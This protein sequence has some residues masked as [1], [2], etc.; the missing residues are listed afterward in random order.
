M[1]P[2][3]GYC[4]NKCIICWRPVEY[5]EGIE[6]K[7]D[8]DDPKEVVENSIEL[9]KKQLMGFKGNE[10]VNM[11]KFDEAMDPMHF[12][13]SLAG[14]PTIS[15]KLNGLIKEIK[16]KGK[17]TFVVSNGM[18]PEKLR[19]IEP[20]TQLYVS[21]D[22]PNEGLFKEID[23]CTLKDGWQR[24]MESLDIL[25]QLKQKTRTAIRI[26]LIKG[27][28]M[29]NPGQYAEL[30]RKAEPHFV[31]VKAYMWV[32]A[33]Q[34]RLEI[35]NMPFHQDVKAFAEEIAKH[36]DY[37]IIDEQPESRVVLMMQEDFPERIMKF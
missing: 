26:T 15:P 31:E 23:K 8:V 14:E 20:P 9:Q 18:L 32:G 33:S 13:I 22:A 4:Q 11:K 24:L 6:I 19:E 28:N 21:V 35:E 16:D 29:A 34:E 2:S 7:G 30:I 37:K 10:Q 36:C 1:T 12:A 25:E 27:K 17:S 3:V 5:T